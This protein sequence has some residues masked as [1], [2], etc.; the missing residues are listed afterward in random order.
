M[1]RKGSRAKAQQNKE[2]IKGILISLFCLTIVGIG[3]YVYLQRPDSVD[4]VTL[5]PAEGPLAH[6]VLLVDKTD[7]L[8]FTQKQAFNVIIQELIEKR[9]P[10]GAL[11][12]VFVLGENFTENSAPLIE[13]CNPGTGADKNK[14]TSNL[15]RLQAQY[16]KKFVEPLLKQSESLVSTQ[17]SKESPIFEMLQLVGIN[18]FRKH[19][20]QGERRLILMSDMLHNTQQFTMYKGAVDFTQF[21]SSDYAKK[22]QLELPGVQVEVHYLMNSPQLQTKRNLKFWEEYFNKAGARIVEVRPLEG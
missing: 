1:S 16:R 8:N 17:P 20:I 6:Y 12:S 13:L 5:C 7:P 21:A 2:I 19:S 10:E 9:I 3:G 11:F 4:K 18:A 14:Y 22:R 15:Q